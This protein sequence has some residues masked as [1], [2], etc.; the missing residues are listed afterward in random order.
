M[1]NLVFIFKCMYS[2]CI[3]A[4]LYHCNHEEGY[5][6]ITNVVN[7]MSHCSEY[8]IIAGQPFYIMKYIFTFH[9]HCMGKL[10]FFVLMCDKLI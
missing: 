9:N 10:S 1:A 7:I 3:G 2:I 6:C 4:V 5:I 8:A